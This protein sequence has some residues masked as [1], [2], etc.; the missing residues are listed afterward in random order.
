MTMLIMTNMTKNKLKF[1][2]DLMFQGLLALKTDDLSDNLIDEISDRI[3][4]R[5]CTSPICHSPICH[6]HFTVRQN[7]FRLR[8]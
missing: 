7:L 8:L 3:A 1:I 5:F 6:L 2:P 4:F